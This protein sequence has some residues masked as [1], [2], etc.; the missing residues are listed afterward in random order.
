MNIFKKVAV[1]ASIASVGTLF[2][3]IAH[4]AGGCAVWDRY[5]GSYKL[6]RNESIANLGGRNFPGKKVCTPGCEEC[7]KP[8]SATCT[9]VGNGPMDDKIN[10][11]DVPQGCVL[12]TAEHPGFQ[13]GIVMFPPGRWEDIQWS[14]INDISAV[15]CDCAGDPLSM[16]GTT[17]WGDL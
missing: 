3:P 4:A 12:R 10:G 1:T 11:I 15:K 2:A 6:A 9:I 5:K 8:R 13:G 14:H 16:V 17:P 7:N